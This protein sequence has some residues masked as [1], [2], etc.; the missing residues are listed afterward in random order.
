M[1]HGGGNT[2]VKTHARDLFGREIDV[3]H[4]KG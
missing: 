1:L 3:L 4:V 2:S